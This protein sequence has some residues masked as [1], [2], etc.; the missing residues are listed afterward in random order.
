MILSLVDRRGTDV[1]M[2]DFQGENWRRLRRLAAAVGHPD[3]V[4][5]LVLVDDRNMAD[6]NRQYRR[7]DGVTD[8]LSFSYLEFAGAGAPDLPAGRGYAP[9]DVW[10]GEQ[11]DAAIIGGAVGE[12]IL[13][14]A[15]VAARCA[16]NDWTPATEFPLLV[17]H[18][19]LHLLG[20]DH[21][22]V[23][24]GR[25]MQEHEVAIL[26]GEGLSHPLR[27]GS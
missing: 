24:E 12:L 22:D 10:L 5:D 21:E 27:T 3:W 8:V 13:A 11:S 23:A 1:S 26:A 19:S 14:P 6:L 20:W 9:A 18:G 7:R 15:F 16:E 4:V 2:A 25:A 17:V